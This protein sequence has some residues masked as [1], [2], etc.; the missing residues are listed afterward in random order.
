MEADRD[1]SPSFRFV[2]ISL[3]DAVRFCVY[4]HVV[5]HMK[6]IIDPLY[7]S[8][9]LLIF[10]LIGCRPNSIT[11]VTAAEKI[12]NLVIQ[13]ENET[14]EIQTS[15]D[16]TGNNITVENL[17]LSADYFVDEHHLGS[18][19]ELDSNDTRKPWEREC[20]PN[21][22]REKG[23]GHCL[24]QVSLTEA[25]SETLRNCL[26]SY[27]AQQKPILIDEY[28][29]FIDLKSRYTAQVKN[30]IDSLQRGELGTQ[31]FQEKMARYQSSFKEEFSRQRNANKNLSMMSVNYRKALETIKITLSESQFKQFYLCHK[32]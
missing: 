13:A 10:I 24:Q 21:F 25:Q 7:L 11:P 22:L 5:T 9:S 15:I 27:A 23:F 17:A 28:E 32:R 14:Q 29:Q 8:I 12:S 20:N 3:G 2:W 30:D 6:K 16:L 31:S 4:G 1:N 26:K 18:E 19:F